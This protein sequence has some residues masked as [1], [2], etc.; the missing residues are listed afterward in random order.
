MPRLLKTFSVRIHIAYRMKKT[1]WWAPNDKIDNCI[2]N[3]KWEEK[4]LHQQLRQT[5]V[6]EM[7]MQLFLLPAP[8][9]Q[10]YLQDFFSSDGIDLKKTKE[11]NLHTIQL[12]ITQGLS[13]LRQF[14]WVTSRNSSVFSHGSF[15]FAELQGTNRRQELQL[16]EMLDF[17][18]LC[19][20]T[21]RILFRYCTE[22]RL[23]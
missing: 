18:E 21:P 5:R 10:R 1:T 8:T 19:I 17:F 14:T 11:N 22:R 3:E 13:S 20:A 9:V 15:S 12:K 2:Q 6:D 4:K 7:L 16:W 23:Q